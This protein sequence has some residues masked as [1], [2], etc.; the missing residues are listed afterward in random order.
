MGSRGE[1]PSPKH[2]SRARA[3]ACPE[4][5]LGMMHSAGLGQRRLVVEYLGHKAPVGVPTPLCA[6]VTGAP[7]HLVTPAAAEKQG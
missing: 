2:R 5:P 3:A 7:S 1:P 6:L 4:R